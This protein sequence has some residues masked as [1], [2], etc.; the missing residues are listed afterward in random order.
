MEKL[1]L[2][3]DDGRLETDP[4]ILDRLADILADKVVQRLQEKGL[5][6]EAQSP[7]WS[8]PAASTVSDAPGPY[9][10]QST[11][12]VEKIHSATAKAPGQAN[13]ESGQSQSSGAQKKEMISGFSEEASKELAGLTT[14][15]MENL[16]QT[17]STFDVDGIGIVSKHEVKMALAQF[18]Q[19]LSDDQVCIRVCC[20]DRERSICACMRGARTLL[21]TT[22]TGITIFTLLTM[23]IY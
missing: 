4:S 17:F 10:P 5:V 21:S 1:L 18:G 23:H 7:L 2:A 20:H 6:G 16:M 15:E 3:N 19:R 12:E 9:S 13:E 8:S 22:V 14:A 11:P